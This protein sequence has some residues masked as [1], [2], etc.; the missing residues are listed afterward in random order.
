VLPVAGLFAAFFT[1]AAPP[2]LAARA[3]V[4]RLV[5]IV[6]LPVTFSYSDA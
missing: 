4:L 5:N 3:M 1:L 6:I 2:A